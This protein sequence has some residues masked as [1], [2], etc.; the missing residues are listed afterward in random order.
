MLSKILVVEDSRAFRKY[1]NIQLSQAGFQVIFAESITQ[2]R[3]ILSKESDF[4]CSVLDY[5]LPDG[6]DGEIIEHVLSYGVQA[7]ILTAHFSDNIREKVLSKGVIDYLLKDS[8]SSVSY[9]IPLL[10]RLQENSRH[11][12]LV[13]E[14]S[15]T[16]R[17]H[18]IHLLTRQNLQVIAAENGEQAIQLLQQHPDISLIITDHDMP[19]K[20]GITMIRE[21]RRKFDRNQLAILGLSGSSDRSMT[22]RFLKAGAND[23]LYKP[24]NQ[25]ELYCRIHHILNM[26]DTSDKLYKMANQDA[27]TGLWNRRYFFSQQS[28]TRS[29]EDKS[30]AMLDID[31]FKKVNDNYGHDG[32][33][34]VLVAISQQLQAHFSDAIVAR[35]GGEE[36]C[37]QS[38]G[39]RAIFVPKLEL[40]RHKIE[41]LTMKYNDEEIKITVSIG[42]SVGNK[43][44]DEMLSE[45]D[46]HL[47]KAKANGRNQVIYQ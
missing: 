32:G 13:V 20:D 34:T 16:V 14:D 46:A 47:Y 7:I 22:A 17:S 18:L 35:F 12:A 1:L 40:M 39:D 41:Q 11:K 31:F 9:L 44:I 33:D 28:N 23:F 30:I 38:N 6:H 29:D 26:K 19:K 36:F 45:A 24:F 3:E 43:P 4:L 25:E 2:A 42:I 21:I 5:C 10:Q 37:I 8:A 27:L 15:V